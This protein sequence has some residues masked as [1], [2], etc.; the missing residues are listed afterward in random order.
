MTKNLVGFAT[1]VHPLSGM[2]INYIKYIFII[3]IQKRING[4]IAT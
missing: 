1:F 3:K 2:R 4:I